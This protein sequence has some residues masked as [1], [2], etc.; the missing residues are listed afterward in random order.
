MFDK[1]T[2]AD[3]ST[4][5]RHGGTGLGLAIAQSIVHQMGGSIG[6]TSTVGAGSTFFFDIV[7]TQADSLDTDPPVLLDDAPD[8]LL[9][10]S[11]CCLCKMLLVDGAP[12]NM[13]ATWEAL[14]MYNIPSRGFTNVADALDMA[15]LMASDTWP[16]PNTGLLPSFLGAE[17]LAV[18]GDSIPPARVA[19]LRLNT[20]SPAPPPPPQVRR[21]S[22]SQADGP[23]SAISSPSQTALSAPPPAMIAL[24]HEHW[25]CAVLEWRALTSD[26]GQLAAA[27]EIAKLMPIVVVKTRW[28]MDSP[29]TV[30][31]D[32]SPTTAMASIARGAGGGSQPI[33]SGSIALPELPGR[34]R[35]VVPFVV[36]P[37]RL[38]TL[39]KAI[40][41]AHEE[42]NR[43]GAHAGAAVHEQAGG[44]LANEAS[45]LLGGKNA[46]LPQAQ[47]RPS[48]RAATPT[49]PVSPPIESADGTA[50]SINVLVV[51]DNSINQMV[52]SKL[53]K[54]L[55]HSVGVASSGAE[56]L[57]KLAAPG[58]RFDLV[59]MDMMMPEMDGIE[60][61]RRLRASGNAHANVRVVALTAN[62]SETD[63]DL[64]MSA[65]MDGFM[66]KPVKL[67][68]L[69]N[70]I[71]NNGER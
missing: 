61:T 59:L 54:K 58:N 43:G 10:A 60:T 13:R 17:L 33:V 68:G 4:T 52:T 20:A 12:L 62:S 7:F 16:L 57:A 49:S 8:E 6:V 36:R 56:A 44:P 11:Y 46:F 19:A 38:R 2:Q 66:A 26:A 34:G 50:R 67:N 37:G 9:H 64:C 48:A 31:R 69:A 15:R 47:P 65:G 21:G 5:R 53:L 29:D 3:L 41:H 24:D 63:R 27:Y 1:Y 70:C 14:H 30:S 39:W 71:A 42:W 32:E 22:M 51:D 28:D 23:P 45:V 18:L 35:V 40:S 55:G 25:H